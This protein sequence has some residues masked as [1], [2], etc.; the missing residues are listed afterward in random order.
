MENVKLFDHSD[1]S[2]F[3]ESMKNPHGI[4]QTEIYE[5]QYYIEDLI[6]QVHKCVQFKYANVIIFRF[7]YKSQFDQETDRAVT[8]WSN[9]VKATEGGIG[10]MIKYFNKRLYNDYNGLFSQALNEYEKEY[11][12][13]NNL[14]Q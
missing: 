10:K 12:K 6:P 2:T 11:R 7:D 9:I 3:K 1:V 5:D 13:V 8:Y 4:I 14:N